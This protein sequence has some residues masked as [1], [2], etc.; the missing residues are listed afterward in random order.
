MLAALLFVAE[1]GLIIVAAIT[2]LKIGWV[3]DIFIF[4]NIKKISNSA[5]PLQLAIPHDKVSSLCE[6]L[7][8]P[9]YFLTILLINFTP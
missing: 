1:I 5:Y 6:Y 7:I 8:D 9:S 2:C 3:C 4:R